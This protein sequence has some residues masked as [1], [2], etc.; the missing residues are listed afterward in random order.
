[1]RWL[2]FF[3]LTFC[4]LAF[5]QP[6]NSTWRGEWYLNGD[7]SILR[8]SNITILNT[9]SGV[10]TSA[11]EFQFIDQSNK[12]VVVFEWINAPPKD[13]TAPEATVADDGLYNVC[14]Y[15]GSVISK[16]ELLTKL[17]NE[18]VSLKDS[19]QSISA[20]K[21]N[22]QNNNIRKSLKFIDGLS[23]DR[24]RAIEC[25]QY[26]YSKNSKNYELLGS[27]DVDEF[28]F[29]DQNKVYRWSDNL[30]IGGIDV[31]TYSRR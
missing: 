28:F 29:Y 23:G 15:R 10:N 5:A 9:S 4:D 27:G 17:S 2:L 26:V 3:L 31:E 7:K 8:I 6:L 12:S 16:K 1:M 18:K 11:E 25:T 24:Y 14:F 22:Y 20:K 13:G 21:F 30:A 19:N